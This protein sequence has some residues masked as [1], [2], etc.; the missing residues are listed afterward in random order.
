MTRGGAISTQVKKQRGG[1]G[2]EGSPIPN[3]P[4]W[5][6]DASRPLMGQRPARHLAQS[7]FLLLVPILLIFPFG[8][9]PRSP[10]AA[11]CG[12]RGSRFSLGLCS[13]SSFMAMAL[14]L[15]VE[16]RPKCPYRAP[17]TAGPL[18]SLLR[19]TLVTA[20]P[21]TSAPSDITTPRSVGPREDLAR[22]QGARLP[23]VKRF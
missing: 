23:S 4:P 15:T 6:V 11:A 1:V 2:E 21:P 14:L 17:T 19:P 12:L 20:P 5:V 3:H 10:T 7:L 13:F 16:A 22:L 18:P 9:I 8:A